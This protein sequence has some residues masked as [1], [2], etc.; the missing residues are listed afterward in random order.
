M[1][2]KVGN[3]IPVSTNFIKSHPAIPVYNGDEYRKP[4]CCYLPYRNWIQ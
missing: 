1:Q 4:I 3:S 2:L